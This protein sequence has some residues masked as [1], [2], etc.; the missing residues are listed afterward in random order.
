VRLI[1]MSGLAVLAAMATMAF[2]G[3]GS[4]SADVLCLSG[5]TAGGECTG[6]GHTELTIKALGSSELKTE[7]GNVTCH[8]DVEGLLEKS[9][10]SHKGLLGKISSLS[11]TKCE[12]TCDAAKPL[13]LPWHALGSGLNQHMVV[14]SGGTGN[15]TGLLEGCTFFN[16][17]C[18][19]SAASVLLNFVGGNPAK[20]VA[21]NVPLTRSGHSGF[22]SATGTWNGSFEI[23][24]PA[25][26]LHLA[27]LP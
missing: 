21:S 10:G 3:A 14:S 16:V 13:N 15:P 1:K 23:T 7:V 2:A 9:L 11:W 18:Q 5:L 27:S 24:S 22:C 17:N 25:S 20:L 12:G 4:A 8:T 19:Y 6:V 26:L